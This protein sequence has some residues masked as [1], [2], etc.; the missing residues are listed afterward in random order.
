MRSP[1][2]YEFWKDRSD[3]Y[4][5]LFDEEQARKDREEKREYLASQILKVS[6]RPI[7]WLDIGTGEGSKIAEII[8]HIRR[9]EPS[10]RIELT[11]IEP[12]KHV[13]PVLR[14]QLKTIPG[15]TLEIKNQ[16]FSTDLLEPVAYDCVSFFHA[17][18]YLG[19]ERDELE[20]IYKKATCSL[21]SGGV[22]LFQAV[23][24]E[25][26]FQQLQMLIR[27]GEP[28]YVEWSQGRHIASVAKDLGTIEQKEF[29]THFNATD[30]LAGG[31]FSPDLEKKFLGL[32][33]FVTQLED[34]IP[35]DE[36]R[37]VF[38]LKMQ[39][40]A[41]ED[42]DRKYLNFNDIVVALRKV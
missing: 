37:N 16:E 6:S 4:L 2:K 14:E 31:S 19:V 13:I 27:D 8:E 9:I 34:A 21:Q 10:I 42:T 23:D 39:E 38:I 35:S 18:Y 30:L 15:V 1:L 7:R 24:E 20:G 36:Q 25:A 40:L 29:P 11:A 5:D 33:R 32:Y 26:D 28:A 41:K 12:S 17:A 22:L 3:Y